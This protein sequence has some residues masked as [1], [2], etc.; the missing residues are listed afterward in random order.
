MRRILFSLSLALGSCGSEEPLGSSRAAIAR[1]VADPTASAVVAVVDTSRGTFCS[2]VLVSD[3][4][5][6]TAR[7]CVA[8]IVD[9][10]VVDCR[11]TSFGPL[12]EAT[13]VQVLT[14]DDTAIPTRRHDVVRVLAP[15]DPSFCGNDLAAL[16]LDRPI[17]DATPLPLRIGEDV[18][19]S[20]VYSA[21][22]FGRDGA[23]AP[24]GT[25]RRRDDLRVSCVGR[26]CLSSQITDQEWWGEGAVCEGDSGGP[27]LDPEGRVIGIASRKRDGCSAT[28]Y[29]DLARSSAFMASA[30]GEAERTPTTRDGCAYAGAGARAGS[31]LGASLGPLLAL[32]LLTRAAG[33][34]R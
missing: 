13:A 2:G 26:A 32:L 6:L 23:D 29:L 25:R 24:S 7:H 22:G 33:R 34:S 18:Q 30:L 21:I 16:V 5:V 9:G 8:P 4:M 28:V 15:E 19:A 1:G 20:E 31:S 27:A 10:P 11:K 12:S 3:R 14:T 17:E